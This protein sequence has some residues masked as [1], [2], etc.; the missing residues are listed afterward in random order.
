MEEVYYSKSSIEEAFKKFPL[1]WNSF[2]KDTINSVEPS[3]VSSVKEAT[4]DSEFDEC[5]Q[6]VCSNCGIELQSW[7]RIERDEDDGEETCHEYRFL[8]CPNC[9]AKIVG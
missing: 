2:V 7:V 3:N 8:Y 6:F 1:T 5:D 9:G 4:N